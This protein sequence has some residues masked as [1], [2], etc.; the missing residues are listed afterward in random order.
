V[1]IASLVLIVAF[2]ITL[3]FVVARLVTGA[4]Y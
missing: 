4:A 1:L 3:A 2:A